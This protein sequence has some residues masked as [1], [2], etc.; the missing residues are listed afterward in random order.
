MPRPPVVT[1]GVLGRSV[2]WN[3]A[4][5]GLTD[6]VVIVVGVQWHAMT[7]LSLVKPYVEFT[8]NGVDGGVPGR[9]GESVNAQAELSLQPL[10]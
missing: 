4:H 7:P 6:E 1:A 5:A 9:R 10:G 3:R 8:G 2:T